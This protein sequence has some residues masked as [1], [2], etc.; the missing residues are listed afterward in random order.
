MTGGIAY[1]K[2]D[3]EGGFVCAGVD[4]VC[5][6]GS[7]VAALGGY[8]V[9]FLSDVEFSEYRIVSL[10][11]LE[12]LDL[13]LVDARTLNPIEDSLCMVKIEYPETLFSI[14]PPL[15]FSKAE[16]VEVRSGWLSLEGVHR[17]GQRLVVEVEGYY[18]GSAN[19]RED[20]R[21]DVIELQRG[22]DVALVVVDAKSGAPIKALS[23][24]VVRSQ[25]RDDGSE[26]FGYSG[27]DKTRRSSVGRYYIDGGEFSPR[28]KVL[29][30]VVAPGYRPSEQVQLKA[31]GGSPIEFELMVSLEA[32]DD[33]R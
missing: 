3:G 18:L 13:R 31:A 24:E 27:F 10:E 16:E 29:Y 33:S 20:P 26:Q 32:E 6:R 9:A 11:Y 1:A 2:C 12:N 5:H 23:V 21:A 7:L 8:S 19:L 25:Y 30:R 15:Q 22:G 4:T 14:I 28:D 17:V